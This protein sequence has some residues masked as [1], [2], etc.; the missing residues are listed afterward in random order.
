MVSFRVLRHQRWI[1]T[2]SCCAPGTESAL[3]LNGLS[4]LPEE[5]LRAG[6]RELGNGVWQTDLSVPAVHCGACIS[7]IEHEL[8][9]M[10]GVVDAR[11]NLS[12]KRVAIKWQDGDGIP[13]FVPALAAIGYPAHLFDITADESDK[14]MARLLKALAISGFAAA[15]IMLLSVSVWSGAESATRDLFHWVSALIAIPALIWSGRIF[16][17]SAWNALRHGRTNMDVPISIGITLAY[18]MSIYET[19]N[20]GEHAYF[21][22]A[23]SLLFFLLIGRTLDHLMREKAR[24][25][26]KGL[27]RLAARGALVEQPDGSR[28]WMPVGDILPG[29]RVLL[30]AGERVP[31]DGKVEIGS[32]ELDC[33]LVTGESAPQT[34]MPGQD[35]RA[36]TL[37][38]VAPITMVATARAD[39]S[40]LAEMIRLMEAAEGG[41]ARYRRIADRASQLYA[42][43]VHLTAFLAFLGW[44]FASGDW[45]RSITIAIAVLIITCPCALGLAVPIVQVVAARRLFEKGIMVKD[46]SAMERL[47]EAGAVVFDKTGTLTLGKPRLV[48]A[49]GAASEH[50]SSA[51]GLASNSRHPLSLALLEEAG[52]YR[53][54][55]FTDVTE[56]PGFGIEGRSGKSVW[57]LGRRDWATNDA[58]GL[59]ESRG[60]EAVLSCDGKELTTFHFADQ[61]RPDAKSA[62]AELAQSG[63]NPAIL[64][65]DT[66]SSVEQIA[67]QLG[68]ANWIGAMLPAGKLQKIKDLSEAGTKAL[69]VGDGLNDAPALRAAHVSMAPATAADI[70]R[71]AADFVFLRDSLSAVPFAFDISTRAGKLIR[72]NFVIAIVYNFLAVPLAVMGY[73]TPLVAALA[74][75]GSSILVV[76]NAMRLMR[77]ERKNLSKTTPMPL[78]VSMEPAE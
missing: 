27:A 19:M 51:A 12:T 47:A 8:K 45:H 25:A 62:I 39:Q 56:V 61:L 53:L 70:G 18:G 5:E 9:A 10:E 64:S 50:L 35:L 73:V 43:V 66:P 57:R 63:L 55:S 69:M 15:N 11:V 31:V 72:E 16:F 28:S 46:G 17:S 22:A 13:H 42:P 52:A 33:A 20:H 6:S 21:D 68:I 58:N 36:G 32:S 40:F 24:V 60:T 65:G 34:V 49:N 74:M 23:V 38:L 3:D 7:T 76:A 14:E 44:M 59:L 41:K 71:N 1:E 37:N 29:M 54:K 26:V 77:G 78:G 67:R 30:A 4:A 75:S 2:M 48:S